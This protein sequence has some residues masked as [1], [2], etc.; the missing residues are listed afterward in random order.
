M[1]KR[2]PKED[3]HTFEQRLYIL[4]YLI[5]AVFVALGIRFYILQVAHHQTY[6]Q[7]AE[8]NRIRETP[9]IAP[10]GAIYDREGRFLVDNRAAT[11][12]VIYPEWIS[13][14]DETIRFLVNDL[15]IER[16]PLVADLN[17]PKR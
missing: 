1:S 15:G 13:N 5:L 3:S 2:D 8:N 9:V 7:Q 11:N 10:R 17:D 4:Q 12:V 14:K 6:Q 16:G